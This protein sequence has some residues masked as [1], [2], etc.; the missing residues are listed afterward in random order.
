MRCS[1]ASSVTDFWGCM[2]V[3]KLDYKYKHE[4]NITTAKAWDFGKDASQRS[5]HGMPAV[6][7]YSKA[8]STKQRA[9][10]N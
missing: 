4:A 1:S 6:K 8:P 2:G 7:V 3:C 10:R 5:V 9:L